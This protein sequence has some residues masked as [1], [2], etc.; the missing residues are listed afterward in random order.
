MDATERKIAC[1]EISEMLKLAIDSHMSGKLT[2]RE[3][4]TRME[5][6]YADRADE[7]L[8]EA[9]ADDEPTSN[10]YTPCPQCGMDSIGGDLCGWCDGSLD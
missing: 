8:A 10:G 5:A 1:R 6:R 2:F 9:L 4:A 3:R 7:L